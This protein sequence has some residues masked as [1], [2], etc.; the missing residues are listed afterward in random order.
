MAATLK[1]LRA[2]RGMNQMRLAILSRVH[3]TKISLSENGLVGFHPDEKQRIADALGVKVSDVFWG[4]GVTPS[5]RV[6]RGGSL[7]SREA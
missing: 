4:E 5:R 1:V 6:G 3:Q 2:E 7:V